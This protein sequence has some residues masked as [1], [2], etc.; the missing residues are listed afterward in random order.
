MIKNYFKI[1]ARSIGKEGVFSGINVL[2]LSVALSAFLVIYVLV[3]FHLS[4]EK[5]EKD[6]D[7]IYRVVSNYTFNGE[8]YHTSGILSPLGRA[9]RKDLAGIEEAAPF[10]IWDRDLKIAIPSA[11][12]KARVIFKNQKDFIFADLSYF[13]FLGYQWLAGSPATALN[14]PYQL[15]GGQECAC[16]G[17]GGGFQPA[18]FS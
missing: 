15:V 18:V 3:H 1:A 11:N 4:F 6:G 5:F 14:Q 12:Q 13:H 16:C 7:R 17:G 10:R 9:I 2:G 8:K